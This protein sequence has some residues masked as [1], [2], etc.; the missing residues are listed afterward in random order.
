MFTPQARRFHRK[1]PCQ[2][3]RCRH[4]ETTCCSCFHRA[5]RDDDP[6]TENENEN[7]TETLTSSHTWS[8]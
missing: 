4:F 1:V 2:P 7:E 5:C 6:R 3:F 8:S